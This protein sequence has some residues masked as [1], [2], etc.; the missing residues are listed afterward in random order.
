MYGYPGVINQSVEGNKYLCVS[1]E[2]EMKM[3]QPLRLMSVAAGLYILSRP[4]LEED[5]Q[6]V[7]ASAL[8]VV[9]WSGW[10]WNKARLEMNKAYSSSYSG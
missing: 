2:T 7:Q 9:L 8:A 4:N 1:H 6:L 3:V 10:V 5:R